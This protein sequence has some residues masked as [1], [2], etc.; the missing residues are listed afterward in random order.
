MFGFLSGKKKN[1]RNSV[2]R[3]NRINTFS[4]IVNTANAH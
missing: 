2:P 4:V 3:Y 1:I